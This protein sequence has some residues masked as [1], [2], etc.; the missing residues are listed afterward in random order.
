M[1]HKTNT[2]II[3]PSLAAGN[4]M[5]IQD[6]IKELENAGITHIHFDVMDGHF[7]PLLT[8]GIPILEQ[9][10]KITSLHLDVHIMVSNP[11]EVFVHYL[12][13]GADTLTF[14]VE[15]AKHPHRICQGIRSF[16]KR[17]GVAVNPGT[18]ESQ[19]EYLLAEI[20]QVTIMGVNPGYSRQQHISSSAEKIRR[21]RQLCSPLAQKPD[22]QIDGGVNLENIKSLVAAGANILVAGGSVF[23]DKGIKTSVDALKK[24][25]ES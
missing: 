17:A 11:D 2:F 18:H 1:S 12:E 24:A 16:G 22:I 21:V 10:R 23:N 20:D 6:Q 7:V 3:A 14:P 4:L 15:S 19:I 13:A 8:I 25:G 9:L 5:R